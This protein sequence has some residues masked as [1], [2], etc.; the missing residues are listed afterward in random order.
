[1][2]NPVGVNT[3]GLGSTRTALGMFRFWN[4]N[5]GNYSV[6]SAWTAVSPAN[7]VLDND[8][9]GAAA[10]PSVPGG[11]VRGTAW[12]DSNRDGLR[13]PWEAPLAGLAL[14]L[15]G[16]TVVTDADGRY[17]FYGMAD[18]TYTLTADLPAGLQASIPAVTLTAGRGQ[19]IGLAVARQASNTIFLPLMSR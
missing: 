11:T 10:L 6:V 2:I 17:A 13:Q 9:G 19:A 4:V 5:P 18:G 1:V 12:L 8:G 3:S 15:N 14:I 16:Q 7:L